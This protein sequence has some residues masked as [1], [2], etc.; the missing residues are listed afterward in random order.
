M[1][2]SRLLVLAAALALM[3]ALVGCS[4]GSRHDA[5]SSRAGV[6]PAPFAH[7]GAAPP[8]AAAEGLLVRAHEQG[9]FAVAGDQHQLVWEQGPLQGEEKGAKAETT[10]RWRALA[11]GRTK[12]LARPVNGLE[13]MAFAAGWAAY[14]VDRGDHSELLAVRG[15][16]GERTVL[17]EDMLAPPVARGD[18]L[19]WGEQQSGRQHVV[20]RDM[21]DGRSWIAA[22]LAPCSHGHCYRL[23]AVALAD[24]GVVFSRGAIGPQPSIIMRRRFTG[25]P[26]QQTLLRGDP[27]PRLVPSSAGAAFTWSGH[28]L[29]RWDF[30][31][32][33]PKQVELPGMAAPVAF[34][35]GRWLYLRGN[36]CRPALVAQLPDGRT[37]TVV[38]PPELGRWA[39]RYA[40]VCYELQ[41]LSWAAATPLSAWALVREGFSQESCSDKGLV[42]VALASPSP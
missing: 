6:K 7:A 20:V 41:S 40:D 3:L 16:S 29:Y 17:S 32:A 1:V 14:V 9:I 21:A 35:N 19:A 36:G 2:L 10:L 22:D 4:G 38:A 23:D 37:A 34:E 15:A 30:E 12:I 25:A 8:T 5:V 27:Q 24:D 39:S 31:S 13:G 42:G 33:K 11:N 28:G 18:L 26:A